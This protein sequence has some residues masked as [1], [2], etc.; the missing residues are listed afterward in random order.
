VLG[1][2]ADD[3][4]VAVLVSVTASGLMRTLCQENLVIAIVDRESFP[5]KIVS[6]STVR[7]STTRRKT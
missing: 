5:A 3:A 7:S 2:L 1:V 6:R 4:F